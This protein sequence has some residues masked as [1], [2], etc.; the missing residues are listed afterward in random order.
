MT[1]CRSHNEFNIRSDQKFNRDQILLTWFCKRHKVTI[2]KVNKMWE[3]RRIIFPYFDCTN[4][5]SLSPW[6]QLIGL[7]LLGG[8]RFS[9]SW[10]SS[11]IFPLFYPVHD[12]FFNTTAAAFGCYLMLLISSRCPIRKFL[13]KHGLVCTSIPP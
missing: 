5:E 11:S 6:R 10:W 3:T 1:T 13:E 2:L 8:E 12:S 7:F 4:C 9:I